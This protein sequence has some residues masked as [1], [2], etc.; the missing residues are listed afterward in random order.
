LSRLLRELG[1]GRL[2]GSHGVRRWFQD[3]D[4]D[5][6]FWLDA[7]GAAHAFQLCYDRNGNEGAITW[8]RSTGFGHDRVD[9]GEQSPKRAM[10]PILRT[11]TAA[12]YFRI[13]NRFLAA[14]TECPREVRDFVVA[15]LR[16]YRVALYGT[17]RKPRRPRKPAG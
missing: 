7:A 12:P 16:E 2:D 6:Y 17:P 5:L 13:Y 9:S 1:T 15:R 3:D 11:A 10:T 14:S 8:E 4:F